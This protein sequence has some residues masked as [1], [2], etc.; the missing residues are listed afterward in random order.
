MRAIKLLAAVLSCLL[1]SGCVTTM[2][3]AAAADAKLQCLSDPDD[4]PE[5]A[6]TRGEFPFVLEYERDG[7]HESVRDVQ[8]CEFKGRTCTMYGR[9][10]VWKSSLASGKAAIVLL[11]PDADKAY[12]AS[13]G[14]CPAMMSETAYRRVVENPEYPAS[15]VTYRNG[16]LERAEG[17][18][19][20][21]AELD[22]L[23][24]RVTRFE[25][26]SSE[27]PR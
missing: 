18:I 6:R 5:P 9:D 3:L 4:N 26:G 12:L 20:V 27:A 11:R 1:L 16:K 17:G 25:Q 19:W 15:L 23:G 2:V 8:V 7:R 10:E 13:L 14:S 22:T 21:K 24:I